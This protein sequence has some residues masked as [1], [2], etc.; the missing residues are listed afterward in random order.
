M[1]SIN[2]VFK[3]FRIGKKHQG[4]LARVLSFF[5]GKEPKRTIFAL[6]NVSLD[7]KKGEVLGIVGKNGSGKSTLLRTI[8]KIYEKDKGRIK[9][10]GSLM[11]LSGLEKGMMGRLSALDNIYLIGSVLGLGRKDVRKII[12]PVLEFAGL[13]EHLNTKLYQ[14]SSGMLSRM[15][16][17]MIINSIFYK[18][19]DILLLDEVFVSGNDFE[20]EKRSFDKMNEMIRKGTTIIIV[21]HR[22]DIIQKFCERVILM[23]NGRIRNI[24][25][26]KDI[27][28]EYE[29]G[30]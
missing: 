26:T 17:S 28:S 10:G 27:L 29:K 20:F 23:E 5:S 15:A 12:K 13:E 7:I 19:P 16:F 4:A 1:I 3:K 14:F 8:A 18:K 11:I 24:G 9:C 30:L 21:S 25:K 6:K 2:N 22:K